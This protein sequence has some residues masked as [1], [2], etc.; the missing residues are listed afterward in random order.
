MIKI[1][2]SITFVSINKLAA[3]AAPN[4]EAMTSNKIPAKIPKK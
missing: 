2:I 1:M 4:P 3:A